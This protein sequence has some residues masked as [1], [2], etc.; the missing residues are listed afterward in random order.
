MILIRYGN[1]I[2]VQ[3]IETVTI[4]LIVVIL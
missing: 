1:V 3:K 4:T 2:I